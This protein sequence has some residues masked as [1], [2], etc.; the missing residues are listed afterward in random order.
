MIHHNLEDEIY[1]NLL[2][3]LPENV[4]ETTAAADV[5]FSSKNNLTHL[6]IGLVLCLIE[7]NFRF[8]WIKVP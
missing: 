2:L 1:I 5:L 4:K 7:M 3:P 6:P 8:F